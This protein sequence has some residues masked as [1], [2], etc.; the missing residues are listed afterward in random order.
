MTEA[1]ARALGE[2]WIKAGGPSPTRPTLDAWES[3]LAMLERNRPAGADPYVAG[4][5]LALGKVRDAAML[6][7]ETAPEWPD[8][9][10]PGVLG[11]WLATVR[12]RYGLPSLCVRST[13]DGDPDAGWYIENPEIYGT[14]EAEVLVAALESAPPR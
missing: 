10:D 7:R 2:R 3:V 13:D 14:A 6:A 1:K 4:Y 11:T 8:P 9:R 12:E 5:D